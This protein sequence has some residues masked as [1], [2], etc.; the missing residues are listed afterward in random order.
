MVVVREQRTVFGEVPE[1]YDKARAGY[2]S[3]V[4]DDVVG[5][6]GRDPTAVRALEVGAGTGK[7]TTAFATCGVRI[8]ALEPSAPMADVARRNCARFPH[9][10]IDVTTFEDWSPPAERFDLLFAAQSWH[11][12]DPDVRFAKAAAVLRPRG[13][14][15]LM[16][17]R[18]AWH[19]EPLRDEL[20]SLYREVV[21]DLYAQAPGFPGVT[22]T[23]HD[24]DAA[25][26]VIASE[27]FDDVEVHE[28]AWDA[29]FTAD[30]LIEL[31]LTQ[32][33]HRLLAPDARGALFDALR[34]LVAKHGG[35]VVVPHATI[36][37]LARARPAA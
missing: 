18:I 9:V 35:E 32:S 27:R 12:V 20:A 1:L 10:D 28:H 2:S 19:D 3:D 30:G 31:L 36:A 29:T 21:P 7:A 6:V 5:Y 17:H 13:V 14:L 23:D 24:A 37:V 33:H 15:A 4:V 25:A 26:S 16:W 11:W 8:V 34:V 22:G